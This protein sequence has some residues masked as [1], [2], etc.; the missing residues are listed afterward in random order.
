MKY[1]LEQIIE[2]AQHVEL[3]DSIDWSETRLDKD[4]I[5]QIVGSQVYDIYANSDDE[6]HQAILLATVVKLLVENF[7]LNL[8]LHSV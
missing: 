2:L 1:T 6:D 4:R 5:Y 7:V 8:K 3:D